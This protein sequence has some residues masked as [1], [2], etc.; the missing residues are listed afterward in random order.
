[1]L[2]FRASA[3]VDPKSC[4]KVLDEF[5]VVEW[6]AQES[7]GARLKDSRADAYF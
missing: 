1:L 3:V 7:Y 6:L 4:L 5:L 2:L